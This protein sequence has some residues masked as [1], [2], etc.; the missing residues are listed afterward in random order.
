MENNWYSSEN[1]YAPNYRQTT[2]ASKPVTDKKKRRARWIALCVCLLVI[3]AAVYIIV[4]GVGNIWFPASPD[5]PM[6]DP[7]SWQDIL[8]SYYLPPE[9]ADIGLPTAE[10]RNG[11]T[12]TLNDS[13]DGT[14]LSFQEVY[15][16]CAKSIVTIKAVSK[17]TSMYA[18]GTGIII[19]DDGYIVTN[20]HIL[21]GCDRTE[22]GLIDGT[23]YEASLVGADVSSDISLLKIE[24]TGLPAAEFASTNGLLV[25][26]S[27]SAIGNPL[28]ENYRLTMTNGIVSAISRNVKHEGRSMKL[29]QTNAAINEGNSGGALINGFGQVIGITNMKIVSPADG[30]EGIGFAIPS[31]LVKDMIDKFADTTADSGPMLGITVGAV[32]DSMAMYFGIPNGLYVSVVNE[33]SDAYTQ[34]IKHGDII[35][36]VN[37]IEVIST[38]ELAGL[39]QGLSVGDSMQITVWRDGDL[40]DFDVKL[41]EP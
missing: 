24:A 22:I 29:I 5:D 36:S 9:E 19:S 26:D 6:D 10:A 27:V 13:Q 18:W 28:G 31:D 38:D 40:I 7:E 20:T 34:G 14:E 41:T 4:S 35:V 16:K 8:D 17:N 3:A 23:V 32:T 1:W 21:D 11:F 2:A 39:K 33:S 12:L 30:V 37:G 25:G 15:S